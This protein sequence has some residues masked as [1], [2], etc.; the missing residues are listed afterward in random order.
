MHER[1]G[2]PQPLSHTQRKA[3]GAAIPRVT[4]PNQVQHLVRARER[5][6]GPEPAEPRGV[7]H[8][9]DAVQAGKQA[10]VFGHEPDLGAGL[11][12]RFGQWPAKQLDGPRVDRVEPQQ[13][14][15]ERR[16]AGAVRP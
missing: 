6:G 14:A 3:R 12:R 9:L 4:Q 5:V 11:Q 7:H 1:H 10:V 16:F 8:L 13:Q 2:E 15:H